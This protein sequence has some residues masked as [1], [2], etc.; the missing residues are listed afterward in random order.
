[1]NNL[2]GFGLAGFGMIG[3]TH[4]AAMQANLALHEGSVNAKPVALFTRR[5]GE[6]EDLPFEKIYTS[7]PDLLN[8]EKVKVLDI[9]TPNNLHGAEAEAGF[10]SGKGVYCEKPLSSEYSEAER[11]CILAKQT[12]L[13]NQCALT[14]RFRPMV[15]RMKDLL[16]EGVIGQPV[17]FRTSYFHSSYLSADKQMTWRQ[18][19]AVSGG[20]AVMD[21]GIHVL[22]LVRYFLG[23]VKRLRSFSRILHKTRT[24]KEGLTV[25]NNTDEYMQAALEMESGVPGIMEC[26][27]ISRSSLDDNI[28][29]IFG[30]KG[31]LL[32]HGKSFSDL[33]INAEDKD[34]RFINTPGK[35]EKELSPLLPDARQTLGTFID[36][37]AAAI[38][39]M[40]NWAA[41]CAPF[42]GTP[43]FEE[44]FKAQALVHA[45]LRSAAADGSWEAV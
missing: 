7:L 42:S 25:P 22:D 12:G 40:A 38:K 31:S 10:R 15:N 24:T 8:D 20:G 13:P 28:F 23:D 41:G 32:L 33:T 14:M 44:A 11:L 29:E 34:A 5:P 39:N 16:E 9:C 18:D 21:L 37:H 4:L 17:H 26:S 3:R 6:C 30:S 36:S 45:C 19:L 27:R 2:I 35:K 43:V 1:M